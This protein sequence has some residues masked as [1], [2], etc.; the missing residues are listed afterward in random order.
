[1]SC[2]SSSRRC[3]A[4]AQPSAQG[5]GQARS[6]ARTR[7]LSRLH[8]A[9]A[10]LLHQLVLRDLLP[11]RG[12]ARG[13]RSAHAGA[14]APSA[15]AS[16]ACGSPSGSLCRRAGLTRHARQPRRRRS[17]A[18]LR[19]FSSNT[20]S[21][22]LS[23]RARFGMC[24]ASAAACAQH[25]GR[26]ARSTRRHALAARRTRSSAGRAS[27]RRRLARARRRG[28]AVR[29]LPSASLGGATE[30]GSVAPSA[31]AAQRADRL[32]SRPAGSRQLPS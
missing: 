15:A 11:R 29:R 9:Q 14:V 4:A 22:F 23:R 18:H 26:S 16:C 2:F 6:A 19:A 24:R 1:M 10:R 8:P 31:R 27:M 25:A 30:P 7:L 3:A 32:A 13:R 17:S 12:S 5:A 21:V 28:A 20:A